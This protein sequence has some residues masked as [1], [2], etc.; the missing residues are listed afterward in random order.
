MPPMPKCWVWN[1][2]WR[3]PGASHMPSRCDFPVRWNT[4]APLPHLIRNDHRTFLAFLVRVPD[5]GWD[6]SYVTIKSPAD[7]TAEPLALVEFQGCISAKL[8]APNDEVFDGHPLQGRGLEAY[9]AQI[10]LNSPWL[11]ELE[12]INS[13]HQ[14][15]RP[16]SWKSL[17]HYVFWFHDSTFECVA[18]SYSVEV[19]QESFS[20]LLGSVCARITE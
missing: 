16:Q 1:G 19:F 9:T 8:G 4:G 17:S 12:R 7:T 18:Q 11:A 13:V 15:Y 5:P 2:G 14:G 10:V 6:G 3:R 20:A